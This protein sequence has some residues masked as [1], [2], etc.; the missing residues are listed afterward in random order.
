MA[1]FSNWFREN[2]DDLWLYL[3]QLD[4]WQWSTLSAAVIAFSFMCLKG[5]R[6]DR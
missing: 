4:Q 2:I 5:T 6:I 1:N 3:T